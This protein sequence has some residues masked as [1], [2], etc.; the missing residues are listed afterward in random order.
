M[1]LED[2]LSV[3]L[4]GLSSRYPNHV[5]DINKEIVD[6]TVGDLCGWKA[7]ELIDSL[8]EHAPAFLQK[9]V[10]MSISSD[11][12]GIYLLEVSEKTPAFWLHCLGK[13]PPCHEHTQPKK[14]A[15]AQKKASLSYN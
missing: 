1:Y 2:I 11:E 8:S 5:I 6:V 10:R 13:I 3:C 15:Q 12:S 14:Q 7:D 4:Q 9:R